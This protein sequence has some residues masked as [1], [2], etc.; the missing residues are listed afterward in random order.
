MIGK[1]LTIMLI[2]ILYIWRLL[3]PAPN[4]SLAC[5]A[6][7]RLNRSLFLPPSRPRC[8]LHGSSEDCPR[9]SPLV[10][11]VSSVNRLRPSGILALHASDTTPS[12]LDARSRW[13]VRTLR[14]RGIIRGTEEY[15]SDCP[16]PS[17]RC[18]SH[19]PSHTRW[20]NQSHT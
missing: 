7:P 15:L 6:S 20:G 11:V 3:L 16:T 1:M 14:S 13:A 4:P 5:T 18:S 19:I 8:E 2:K 10:R 17:C 12:T 9:H